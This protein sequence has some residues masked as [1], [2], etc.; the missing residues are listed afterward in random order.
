MPEIKMKIVEDLKNPKMRELL[1]KRRSID[2]NDFEAISASMEQIANEIINSSPLLLALQP[3]KPPIK[4]DSGEFTLEKGTSISFDLLSAGDDNRY[5]PVFTS[6]E[7]YEKWTDRGNSVPVQVGFDNVA[8]MLEQ[9]TGCD[10]AVVNPFS[11]NLLIPR[12]LLIRWYE[13]KQ[14]INQGHAN[15][16]I[17]SD[18]PVETY[19]PNPYPMLLSNKLCETAKTLPEVNKLWLRGA[20]LNGEDSYLL[21]ADFNGDRRTVFKALGDSSKPHLGK[22]PLH[23]VELDEGFGKSV[24]E[25]VLPI[26]TKE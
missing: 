23:I 14:I 3:S 12:P 19:A 21:V 17:T 9:N 15:H 20:K 10:G 6:T 4:D 18:T 11:D 24:T 22:M 1:D 16:V 7:D 2:E 25:N 26:Y 5:L 8:S 13:Q